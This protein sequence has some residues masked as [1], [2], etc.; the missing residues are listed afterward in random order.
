MTSPTSTSPPPALWR[1]WLMIAV[2]MMLTNA[3]Q[4]I[5]GTV[6]GIYLGHLI[7]TDAIAAASAFFPVFFFLL[8]IVIGLS[9]GA[10][11]MI[12]RAWGARDLP[13]VRNIAGTALVMMFAIGIVV[14]L[15]GGL[16][17]SPLMQALGTPAR[18]LD[19]A[20]SYARWMLIGMPIVFLL[21]LTTSMSR[22]TGDAVSPLFT[23]LIATLLS[24]ALTPAFIFGW[25]PFPRLGVASAAASTLLA[26]SIALVWMACHWRRKEH[27][28]APGA[29]LW[30]AVRWQPALVRGILRFGVPA[31]MQMLTMAIAEMALLGMVNRHGANATAAYGA[32]TQVMS[33]LQLP[34]MTLGITASIL[35]AHAIGAGRRERVGAIV[36]TGFLCNLGLTGALT[37]LIYLAAPTIM[38]AFLTDAEVLSL[39]THLLYIVAW[40]VPAMGMAVIMV[41]AMRASGTVWI[42]ALIGVIGLLGIEVPAALLFERIAGLTGIWWAYPLA[43]VAM[44]AMQGLCYRAFRRASY[45]AQTN[46][47]MPAHDSKA[48]TQPVDVQP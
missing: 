9:A 46:M 42:P 5:A 44:L 10:T 3:L 47:S 7:G 20:T 16:F 45:R 36:R 38:R 33:W 22:G 11:V 31:A 37:V 32:V 2:P 40:S 17:A 39:A 27:P 34:V 15:F 21:W 35:C 24:L 41:G 26:F 1:T 14:S 43:F 23:L 29:D 4:S 13:Q 25:G 48:P 30:R 28:L 12:G 19:A 6:D 18:V 8:A